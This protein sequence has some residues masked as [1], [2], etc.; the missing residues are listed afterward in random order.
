MEVTD[1]MSHIEISNRKRKK[2]VP[3]IQYTD[4]TF[5]FMFGFLNYMWY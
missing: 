5:Q 4:T 1:D 3:Q 2:P